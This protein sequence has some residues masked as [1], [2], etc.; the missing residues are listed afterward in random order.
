MIKREELLYSLD[1]LAARA[2]WGLEGE[3]NQTRP[4]SAAHPF[5]ASRIETLVAGFSNQCHLDCPFCYEEHYGRAR[6]GQDDL[7][8]D[9]LIRLIRAHKA[10]T[11]SALASF[12]IGNTGEPLIHKE[13]PRLIRETQDSVNRFSVITSLSVKNDHILDFMAD[14][15]GINKVHLSCDA[16]DARMYER[17][18]INGDFNQ[19][20]ENVKKLKRA[21]KLF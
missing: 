13:F 3:E 20:W 16:G 19:V 7:D 15:P 17:I 21:G 4:G 18:R 9:K 12:R 1:D 11:G 8:M 5:S 10:E 6:R 2:S 14:N